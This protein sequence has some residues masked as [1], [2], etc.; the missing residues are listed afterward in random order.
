M[1]NFFTKTLSLLFVFV[2]ISSLSFAKDQPKGITLTKDNNGYKVDFVLPDYIM[3]NVTAAGNNYINL[4]IPEYGEPTN[5]GQPNLPQ[6]SFSIMVAYDEKN[7]VINVLN[8]IQDLKILNDKIYPVQQPWSKN[9]SL[10]DRPFTID[11]KYYQSTGNINGPFVKISEPFIIAGVKGV[12]VTV[13][14]FAYDPSTNRLMV[15]KT[16]SFRIQLNSEPALSFAPTQS[17]NLLYDAMFLNYSNSKSLGTGRYLII[18]APEFESGLTP[19]VNEKTGL[20]YVVTVVNTTVTGTTNTAILAYIQNLYNNVS[21]RPEFVLLVGDVDKIPE[22]IGVGE[23]TPHTDLNYSM[24]DGT[25]PYADVFLGRFPIQN[26][27]QLTNMINKTL[28]MENAINSLPKK[29]VFC[30]STDN[31]AI[32]E[33]THN[34]CIDSFFVSPP[35]T[36]IK[37][38]THTY[39]ATTQQLTDAL[40]NNQT[41]AIYSGHGSET[42]WADGPPFNV[43]NVNALT[44]TVFPYTYSFSCL[45]GSY[46][47]SSECFSETWVRGTKGASVY[48]GSSVTSYWTEDDILQKRIFR[49]MFVEHLTKTSP[50]FVLGKYLTV[51]YF[52]SITAT[53]RR[54]LE[55][56]NCMG[57]PSIY[58]ATY[59][60]AVATNP[61]PNTE[62]LTGP[63]VV[64]CVVTP[65]GQ[66]IVPGG[67]KLFWTI[68]TTF[69]D[70]VVMTN[71]TG[72]NYT[73]NIPGNGSNATY[74]YYI[75]TVDNTGLIGTA[76]GGAPVNYYSF[77]AS[78][79]IQKPVITHTALPNQPKIMWPATVTANVTDN[80]GIDSVWV[81]WYINSPAN[82]IKHFKLLN[83]SGSTFAAAF[84]SIQS[85]V[86]Y[87]DIIKYRIFA[88]DNSSNH[89]VDS[90]ALFQ[91]TIINQVTINIGTG[92]V[93]S[94]YPFTTYW[95]DGRTQML[96]LAS[97]MTGTTPL[98]SANI[99]K[100]GFNVITA[101]PAAM[102]GFNV[103]LQNTSSTSVS[104][105]V[106]TGWTTCFSG[107]YTLPGTGWQ[108]V[109]LTT[110]FYW[111]GVSNLLVEVCYDNTAYTQYSPVNATANA[112]KT[113]G[114]YTDNSTGCTM[115]GGSSQANRPNISIVMSSVTGTQNIIGNVPGTYSL[116]QNYP[117]PF[118]PVTRI[119]F[120]IPKQGLV[121][122]KVFDILGREIRTLINEVKSPGK[123][124]VDFNGM[125]LSS[126]VYF[127]RIESNGFTDIKRMLLIK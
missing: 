9:I 93:S 44:N 45:T 114:Y 120:D 2:C 52:G 84:N 113:W 105:F 51:Q 48:W 75:K 29:Q 7:P 59:G 24:L 78:T 41:F 107:T 14:P 94:N 111:D 32:T 100:I 3:N 37:L 10:E 58:M 20:G 26:T 40:N 91:F 85:E 34:F 30:A 42:S 47:L 16:G 11:N 121:T 62:N 124:S 123:Y 27:T 109:D 70:S 76:P 33:G 64:N 23:G 98:T 17:F 63:Y 56:Y 80:I 125:E 5:V 99:T 8:R 18:T 92:T 49:A 126:G 55:M 36:N 96:Y 112:S 102:Y 28:Y 67:T 66:P 117:N 15:T 13:C 61:L 73:A 74:R 57:D 71:T 77:T 6:I 88:K 115:T 83:T 82:G 87:N 43:S 68:G 103:R 110:P 69:T 12:M 38:Y 21:T 101:D 53:M 4:G 86:N 65:A 35:Y 119:N 25:D 39:S 108:Y 118:N 72:N 50:S 19:L 1:K 60:P 31:W 127:Y 22:W 122:M 90:S 46:Y 104:G 79:D 97:E 116:S 95:M 54:Y 81:R 89:N 106:S